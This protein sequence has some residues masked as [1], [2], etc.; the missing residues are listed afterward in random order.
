M[1][2]LIKWTKGGYD[3]SRANQIKHQK[4]CGFLSDG[5]V[6]CFGMVIFMVLLGGWQKVC[7]IL[8]LSQ[9]ARQ[10]R[11]F[12]NE[13]SVF[14]KPVCDKNIWLFLILFESDLITFKWLNGFMVLLK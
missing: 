10:I 13:L 14:A 9:K 6:T 11:R 8:C 4:D 5:V 1:N 7:L 2:S 3:N 12:Y